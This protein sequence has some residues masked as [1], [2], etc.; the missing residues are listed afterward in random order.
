MHTVAAILTHAAAVVRLFWVIEWRR[1]WCNFD[2]IPSHAEAPSAVTRSVLKLVC[3]LSAYTVL[4]KM[5]WYLVASQRWGLRWL[6]SQWR[7]QHLD[8]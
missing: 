2:R 4:T 6:S 8:V 5:L 1:W 3:P 7:S